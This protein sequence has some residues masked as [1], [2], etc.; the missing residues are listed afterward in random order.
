MTSE[1]ITVYV[2]GQPVSVHPHDSAAAAAL[3]AGIGYTRRS[4]VSH[5]PRAPYCMMGVC[6]ECLMVIDGVPSRQACM[7][8]VRP[9]MR[10]ER[11]TEVKVW[12]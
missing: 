2:D 4:P 6:F 7:V 3:K 8:R 11:Q 10:I 5:E 9:G 12:A 1:T